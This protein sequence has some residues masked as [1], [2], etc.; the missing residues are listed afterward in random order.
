MSIGFDNRAGER[1]P[2]ASR[3]PCARTPRVGGPTRRR[4]AGA[5][6]TRLVEAARAGDES[7]WAALVAEFGDV[8]RAVT[9]SCRLAPVDAAD[10]FQTTWLRLVENIDQIVDPRRLGAWL[11]TTA[12]RESLHV[13]R[14]AARLV[15]CGEDLPDRPGE[16]PDPVER[17]IAEQTAAALSVALGRLGRRD[18]ALLRMLTAEPAPS[19]QEISATLGMPV[20][21]IGPTRARALARLRGEVAVAG[22]TLAAA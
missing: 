9:R 21:S 10:V 1:M 20:G 17:L 8:V 15:P 4:L 7:A 11:A 19:Y 14:G 3:R 5:E 16:T 13:I 12:R 22:L 18:R 6:L 2:L